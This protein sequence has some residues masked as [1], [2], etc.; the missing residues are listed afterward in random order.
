MQF[1]SFLPFI[2]L[3]ILV[4]LAMVSI[5]ELGHYL[6]GR[7]FKF[8]ITEFAV[9]FGGAIG[10]PKFWCKKSRENIREWK[11]KI[12]ERKKEP[13][14]EGEFFKP[15]YYPEEVKDINS[16]YLFRLQWVNKRRE[17]ITIRWFPLGGYCAFLGD[18]DERAEGAKPFNAHKPWQRL[19]VFFSGAFFNIVSAV[20]FSIIFI[21]IV[22]FSQPVIA[23]V[24]ETGPAAE[25]LMPGD[26]LVGVN[27]RRVGVMN[28]FSELVDGRK[29]GDV[30]ELLIVRDDVE[31]TKS[32]AVRSYV[33][34]D[35]AGKETS[36][37][38]FGILFVDENEEVHFRQQSVGFFRSIG[39]S[40]PFTGKLCVMTLR[41]F[42]SLFT[43]RVSMN[44]VGGPVT[45]VSMMG[46]MTQS[47]FS[48]IFILLPLMAI[49]LGIF[50]LFPLPALDG[51]RMVF[52]AIEWIRGKPINRNIEAM[53]H[54]FGMVLLLGLVILLDVMNAFTRGP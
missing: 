50:N 21:A 9:G 41:A 30:F 53:I 44:Q 36:A 10:I 45:A 37:V 11:K 42:G 34:L 28:S 5:H 17:K 4:L 12:R 47:N 14:K 46:R 15:G 16:N 24:H 18:D 49:N 35:G 3:A 39:Y 32:V 52:T 33:Y 43:G 54:F 48:T 13:V 6:A 20:F 8:E 51:S 2:I 29:E 25:I 1:L 7:L 23:R 31:I 27:G 26:V 40:V 19:I 38:G 22:G